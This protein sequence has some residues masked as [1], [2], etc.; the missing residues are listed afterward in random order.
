MTAPNIPSSWLAD[1]TARADAEPHVYG[2]VGQWDTVLYRLT[3]DE[4]RGR[5]AIDK[6]LRGIDGAAPGLTPE[7]TWGPNE[8]R[9]TTIEWAVRYTDL[10]PLLSPADQTLW[11]TR[12]A[13]RADL[14]LSPVGAGWG[15]RTSDSD[16]TVGH[17]LG[18]CAIDKAL[19]TSYQT[20]TAADLPAG[21][22][23]PSEMR[24]ALARFCQLA[25][26]GEWIESSE[27]NWGTL[28][29]LTMGH[30]F[31]G[32]I[33]EVAAILPAVADQLRRVLLPSLTDSVPW[34]D[35]QDGGR[36][37]KVWNLQSLLCLLAAATGDA[38]GRLRELVAWFDRAGPASWWFGLPRPL[39]WFDLPLPPT[40]TAPPA[41]PALDGFHN[42]PDVGLV[43]YRRGPL[44]V[45]VHAPNQLAVDHQV[46]TA[47]VLVW[48]GGVPILDANRGY[49]MA[50]E[51]LNSVLLSGLNGLTGLMTQFGQVEAVETLAGFRSV[52]RTGG[53]YFDGRG[54]RPPLQT[55][56][57]EWR[58]MVEWDGASLIVTDAFQGRPVPDLDSYRDDAKAMIQGR[59]A[60]WAVVWQ[61]TSEP[62]ANGSLGWT[63]KAAD[64]R[65]VRLT[66]RGHDSV[67]VVAPHPVAGAPE[68]EWSKFWQVR[69]LSDDGAATIQSTLTFA[70]VA[71][72]VPPPSPPPPPVPIPPPPTL[73]IHK[74]VLRIGNLAIPFEQEWTD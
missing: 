21:T 20:R 68:S 25:R 70:T 15:T 30:L 57:D 19:G 34:G 39:R 32:P 38:D 5:R 4:A 10:L 74:G 1:A 67:K 46:P 62:A 55:F 40:P 52:W 14:I 28:Q 18:L 9:E 53:R 65:T 12:L 71:P 50:P 72:P 31:A 51:G 49:V 11:R 17:Y 59:D 61:C 29:L 56:C 23:P 47:N 22:T 42:S 73:V 44:V 8:T 3:G 13:H 36:D 45:A 6:I 64:G 69:L 37:L 26:G 16:Q 66:A 33:P 7:P 41:D 43:T 60:L 35:I 58:R 27:Y 63:W 48:D 54:D 2:D 24:A